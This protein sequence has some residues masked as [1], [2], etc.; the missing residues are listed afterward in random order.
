MKKRKKTAEERQKDTE[1]M[2]KGKEEAIVKR[3][4]L[5]EQK[6]TEKIKKIKKKREEVRQN[7]CFC[8]PLFL[9]LA[10]TL[11]SRASLTPFFHG[12]RP[13]FPPSVSLSSL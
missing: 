5:G 7:T 2:K 1:T 11:I 12:L 9:F 10:L 6:E 4:P 13:S 8:Y 3:G